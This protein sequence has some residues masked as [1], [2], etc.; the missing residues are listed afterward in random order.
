MLPRKT[1]DLW[2]VRWGRLREFGTEGLVQRAGSSGTWT[3]TARHSSGPSPEDALFC[4]ACC[5]VLYLPT[6][7]NRKF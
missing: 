5:A 4:L 3:R 6:F 1:R 2:E 7:K